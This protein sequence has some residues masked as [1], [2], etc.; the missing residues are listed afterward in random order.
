MTK[1]TLGLLAALV[2]GAAAL[3]ALRSDTSAEAT[4]AYPERAFGVPDREA[5]ARIFIADM[6]GRTMDLTRGA[7]GVWLIDDSLV[8][9]PTIVEQMRATLEQLRIDHVPTRAT[10]DVQREYLAA[11]ALKVEAFDAAGEKLTGVLIG[12]SVSKGRGSYMVVDGYDEIFAVRRGMLTG[13]VRPQFDLRGVAAYRSQDF[14]TYDPADIQ[15]VEV[16]YPRAPSRSFAIRRETDGLVL[17]PLA[18]VVGVARRQP[19]ARRLESYLEGFSDVP[20]ARWVNDHD[21]RDSISAMVPFMQIVVATTSARDT[22]ELQPAALLKD[23]V[24]DQANPFNTYWVERGT[25]DF[26]TVQD[27]Q[28]DQLLRGYQDFFQ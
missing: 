23:G 26:V 13:S 16:R 27:H 25:H 18:S 20:L 22:F 17:E 1:T 6:S 9:S 14:M 15:S 2:L 28:I 11:R 12:S 5:V 21:Y 3:Y 4:S 7:D 24:Y 8:A 19:Q 10:A